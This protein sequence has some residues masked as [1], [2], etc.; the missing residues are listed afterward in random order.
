MMPDPQNLPDDARDARLDALER[1]CEAALTQGRL[2]EALTLCDQARETSPA[3]EPLDFLRAYT[4]FLLERLAEARDALDAMQRDWPAHANAAWLR[5][6][7]TR[8]RL[9]DRAP[10]TL[11]AYD[12]ALALDPANQYLQAE[13]ADIL[14]VQGRAGEARVVY[15]ALAQSADDEALRL[16][17]AFNLGVT[18]MTQGDA[19]AARLAFRAVLDA[20]PDYPE[21]QEMYALLAPPSTL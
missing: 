5:A 3:R 20:A 1:Q 2:V 8:R 12:A 15:A 6:A 10:D 19:Q 18:A 11:A 7:L 17:A 14:R 9:G 13:R 16:E 21:A 4:L